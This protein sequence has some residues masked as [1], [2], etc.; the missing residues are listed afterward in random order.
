VQSALG[1]GRRHR[2]A[3]RHQP[4]ARILGAIPGQLRGFMA[5]K[6]LISAGELLQ[7]GEL[8]QSPHWPGQRHALGPGHRGAGD[9]PRSA[10]THFNFHNGDLGNFT[11]IGPSGS[12]KTVL[13]TFLLG[14]GR[15]PEAADRLFR[16]GPRGRARSSAPSAGATTVISPGE[17]TGFNPLALADTPA[18]RAFLADW[19]GQLLA[20]DGGGAGLRRPGDDRRRGRRQLCPTAR[21]PAPALPARAVPRRT[22]AERRRPGPR[23][24]R[25]GARAASTPGCSTTQPTG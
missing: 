14:P 17:A 21:P 10:P 1:R 19:L 25:P 6:A 5:R 23:G 12:G 4:G 22:P 9:D 20:A 2:G 18:N 7:L 15:A 13:L 11:V 16:Q 8:P 3:R 24:S